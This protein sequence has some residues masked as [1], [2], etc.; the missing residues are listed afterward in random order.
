MPIDIDESV[1]AAGFPGSITACA[2]TVGPYR[3]FTLATVSAW[4]A[5]KASSVKC[6][7]RKVSNR[8]TGAPAASRQ[9]ARSPA[10][11]LAGESCLSQA[12]GPPR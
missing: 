4:A 7:P 12:S 10:R 5:P 11:T 1:L 3:A 9:G 2:C 6:G 8:R